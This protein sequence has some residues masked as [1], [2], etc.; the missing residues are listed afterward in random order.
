V[1]IIIDSNIRI[2][3]ILESELRQIKQELTMDNPAYAKKLKMGIPVWGEPRVI[4]L[5]SEK[6]VNGKKEYIIP[7]GYYSR[8]LEQYG[9]TIQVADNRLLLPKVKFPG[10]P[11]LRDYQSPCVMEAV[12]CQ[13]GVPIMPCGSGKT[14]TALGMIAELQ[15]PTLWIT[16]TMDL[17][18]QSMDRAKSRLELSDNQIGVIQGQYCTIGSHITFATVQTL[19]KRDLENIVTKFGCI[20][21]DEA[22]LVFKDAAKARMFESVISQFPAFYR[23][24]LTASEYR[25]DGLI[26]TMFH[27]IGP[28]IYEIE[29]NDKRLPTVTPS[30][31]FIE[32][33]F[34][35][36]P[37]EDE[38][39]NVQKML[40]A[41]KVNE[42]RYIPVMD[43]L[44]NKIVDGDF[45]LVLGESLAYLEHLK[46]VINSTTDR[47]AAFV[48]GDTPKKVR[49]KMM[50]DMRAG[51]YQY[52]FA[53]YQLAKLGLD[54]PRLNK[55][56]LSTP[57]KDKTSIQQAVGRIMRP[58]EGK[59]PSVVYDIY[60]SNVPQ[61]RYWARDR[62]RVYQILGCLVNGGPKVRKV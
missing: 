4:K 23:F 33:Q 61:L 11:T 38:M 45:T 46:D 18:N 42:A 31:E 59:T 32:T 56:V 15:Q 26:N 10:K 48:C 17:L 9:T 14:E 52:L 29:Q 44:K 5:W 21:I 19:T 49:E 37:P 25:G 13:Q 51:K 62:I 47:K 12:N 22:H 24:G 40:A 1:K 20:I 41:M 60:D 27:I 8:L 16:H 28:K 39:F 53:T 57:K 54:I 43:I 2:L 36:H 6:D 58:F 35:Y 34:N 3:E 7:R 50:E 55:L 30:V